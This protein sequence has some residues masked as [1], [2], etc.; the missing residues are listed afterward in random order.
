M[1]LNPISKILRPP[2]MFF[3]V[4]VVVEQGVVDRESGL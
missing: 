2:D 1:Q 4:N 3:T